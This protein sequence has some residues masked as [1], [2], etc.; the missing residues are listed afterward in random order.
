MPLELCENGKGCA[1]LAALLL[2]TAL[3]SIGLKRARP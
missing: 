1:I 3:G 2:L